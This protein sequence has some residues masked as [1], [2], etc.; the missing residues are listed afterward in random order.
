VEKEEYVTNAVDQTWNPR[1]LTSSFEMPLHSRILR[2]RRPKPGSNGEI[3][4]SRFVSVDSRF[5]LVVGIQK[6]FCFVLLFSDE[7]MSLLCTSLML[8]I[9]YLC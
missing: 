3:F 8:I 4:D 1:R 2:R 6:A 7:D 9:I 5:A